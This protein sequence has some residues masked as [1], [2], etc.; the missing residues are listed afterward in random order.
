MSEK[1]R[2]LN[3]IKDFFKITITG[4]CDDLKVGKGNLYSGK[5]SSKV[6][7]GVKD[8]LLKRLNA[9]LENYKKNGGNF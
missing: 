2:D 7:A 6:V 4:I 1:E 5:T 8:E 3:F 9:V